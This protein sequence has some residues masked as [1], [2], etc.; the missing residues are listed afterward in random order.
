MLITMEKKV[1]Y[2]MKDGKLVDANKY[3]HL[4]DGK[5]NNLVEKG[6]NINE[7]KISKDIVLVPNRG[8]VGSTTSIFG[9]GFA[10]R[11]AQDI[12]STIIGA[13]LLTEQLLNI[14]VSKTK[15]GD[16]DKIAPDFEKEISKLPENE[17]IPK[18]KDKAS[19]VAE[20]NGWERNKP[21]ERK[22]TGRLIYTDGKK[23]Y[24]VDT[25]HGRFEVN[26]NRG[27]HQGEINMDLKPTKEAD[28][29]GG[30]DLNVK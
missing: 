29:S 18:V 28:K 5:Y 13:S 25:Q 30:H 9:G 10:L 21:L 23:N 14:Q 15:E 22:N 1:W 2:I 11:N 12:G 16:G 7:M 19:E 6:Y 3:S 4:L 24:S 20:E 8:V 26:N 17:R 27:K